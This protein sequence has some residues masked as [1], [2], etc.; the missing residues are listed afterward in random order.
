MKMW[1][2][3]LGQGSPSR[4]PTDLLPQPTAHRQ[5]QGVQSPCQDLLDIRIGNRQETLLVCLRMCRG[6]AT[7]E[8]AWS[9]P[10]PLS[11]GEDGRVELSQGVQLTEN[12]S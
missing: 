8:W 7:L 6:D 3:G 4:F 5:P 1:S 11:Q 12:P 10:Y 9:L 2:L